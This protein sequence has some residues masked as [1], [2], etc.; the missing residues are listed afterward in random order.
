[1][2]PLVFS[3]DTEY[4]PGYSAAAFEQLRPGMSEHEV[5]ALV[6]P[7]LEKYSIPQS[8]DV[9]QWTRSPGSNSYRERVVVFTNGRVSAT[10]HEFYID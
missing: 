5:L 8:G 3:E 6:G 9:W 1:M 4:A 10:R 2:T 7:P